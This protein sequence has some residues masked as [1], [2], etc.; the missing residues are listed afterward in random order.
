M[1]TLVALYARVSTQQQEQEATIE[2]QVAA[3]ESYA[4]KQGYRMSKELSF[5]DQAVS[6]AELDRPA[7][8]RLRDL[9]PE[10]LFSKV[11]CLSPDRLARQYA[12]QWVV[13]NEL[14]RVGVK[15]I[16]INQPQ[17][18][19]NPHS[20]LFL[21]IQGLFAE[22]ERSLIKERLR[23][24]KLHKIRQGR[25]VSPVAP[26][27]YRYI[28]VSEA[29]GGRWEEKPSEAQVV[30]QIYQ[31]YTAEP[32]M[33]LYEIVTHLRQLGD[34]APARGQKWQY[35]TVQSILKQQDYTGQAYYNRTRMSTEG[36]GRTRKIGRGKKAHA[37]QVPRPQE[38]W[39]PVKVPALIDQASWQRAQERLAMNQK[40]AQR[41]NHQ[42][43]YLLRGLLVC[44]QC[45]RTL[46]G[47]TVADRQT[48][49]CYQ[50][51]EQRSPDIPA[52]RCVVDADI[53]EPLVW[54]SVVTLLDRPQL[55]LDAWQ[56]QSQKD[57][58]PPGE[59]GRLRNRLNTLDRQW[60]RLLD[61]F[62][63]EQ[64]D[65]AELAL[66]KAR[67]DHERL[68]LQQRW[69]ECQRQL[70]KQQTQE[71]ILSDFSAFCSQVKAGLDLSSRSVRQEII[72]LLID[73]IVVSQDE[74]VIKH[75]V[76][77]DDDCR[78]LPSRRFA[79]IFCF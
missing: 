63:D 76:P 40:L 50:G 33:T 46:A 31:W 26:Y 30:K 16:F 68:P 42:N 13:M 25:L 12:H 8:N 56:Q 27:G 79:L 67:I 66:R 6:G 62:Q 59:A 71:Q 36:V 45:G 19:E 39:I 10:G 23:R 38:E 2:S 52:H 48:Y 47:R 5:L 34:A 72:R 4:Q 44:Q 69:Q 17:M 41:N 15:I 11:L 73:H 51:R 20:Q 37:M 49:Y 18:E 3:L 14:E 77:A 61:L 75:I 55:L 35:S 1:E 60:Q 57:A 29:D 65:K 9:A 53:L 64:I 22:Y 74:I 43:F 24:G 58:L 28:P 21:G 32:G 70:D 78:L 7:L 54:Q